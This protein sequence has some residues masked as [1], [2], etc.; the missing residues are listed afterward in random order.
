M[1]VYEQPHVVLWNHN[2][3]EFRPNYFV[4]MDVERKIEMYLCMKTQVRKF[5]SPDTI[6]S[7][8]QVRGAQSN[9]E[10]AEAFEIIRWID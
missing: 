4:E 5:R 10:Y 9:F 6:R 1:L 8:A 7:I 3:R 2:Y